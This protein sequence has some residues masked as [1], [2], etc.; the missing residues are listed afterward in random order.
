MI[1]TLLNTRPAQQAE[2]LNLLLA[3][4]GVQTLNCP[5]LRIDLFDDA[6]SKH[7]VSNDIK[8][9]DKVIFI[10]RNAVHGFVNQN[11]KS[12]LEKLLSAAE[13]YAIGNATRETGLSQ[14]LNISVL[15]EQQFDSEHFLA[16]DVM[17]QVE[18]QHV[19]LVKGREGRDLIE[20]TLLDR[21]AIVHV[22][23]VYERVPA[24]FCNEAWQTFISAQKPVLL[25]TSF[26]SWQ[27]LLQGLKAY[28]VADIE[29]SKVSFFEQPFWLKLDSIVVMSQ[30]IADQ[31][32][33]QG[34]SGRLKVVQTQTNQGII[35]TI[36]NT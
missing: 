30:R 23:E 35:D 11:A 33:E 4:A 1:T 8:N 19:L 24:P 10:S 3:E 22:L 7:V 25:I 15:S 18:G 5:T 36:M 16:H 12:V 20:S 27:A 28:Y 2:A 32:T 21:G 14:G 34:W 9:I 13:L 6:L 26:A 31:M 17:R 29:Q